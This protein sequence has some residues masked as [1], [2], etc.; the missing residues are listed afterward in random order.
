MACVRRLALVAMMVTMVGGVFP[1]PS[2]AQQGPP[3]LRIA[4]G[5]T[6]PPA[7]PSKAGT[8]PAAAARK[9]VGV[10]RGNILAFFSRTNPMAWL[11]AACSIVTVGFILERLVALRRE[12]VIPRDF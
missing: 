9:S 3:T 12:R 10:G 8:T 2:P 7:A 4:P 1:A 11:L 5:A 6:E